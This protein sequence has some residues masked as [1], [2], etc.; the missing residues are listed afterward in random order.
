MN[1]LNIAQ[2]KE[3]LNKTLVLFT[4]S[5][6]PYK[7]FNLDLKDEIIKR[8]VLFNKFR[9]IELDKIYNTI[10]KLYD[11]E[12]SHFYTSFQFSGK[13][14]SSEDI[15]KDLFDGLKL[16]NDCHKLHEEENLK[17]IALDLLNQFNEQLIHKVSDS[18]IDS[19]INPKEN[20]EEKIIY[21]TNKDSFGEEDLEEILE[22]AYKLKASDIHIQTNQPIKVDIHSRFYRLTERDLTVNEVETF[23]KKNIW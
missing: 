2:E 9:D 11:I 16:V 10:Q 23:I 4:I 20:F 17:I 13:E 1:L 14:L 15:V 6:L 8:K 22:H 7:N 3:G 19:L 21:R 12:D 5:A 18:Y